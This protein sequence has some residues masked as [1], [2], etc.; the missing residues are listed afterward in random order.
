MNHPTD[1]IARHVTADVDIS[2]AKPGLC[3]V[4]GQETLCI[5]RDRAISEAF[6]DMRFCASPLSPVVSV[7]VAIAWKHGYRIPGKKRIFCPERQAC[8][9]V[10][11]NQF[12]Q[13]S[14]DEILFIVLHGAPSTPWAGW[15]T[16][17][18]RKHGSIR[19]PINHHP[20]GIWGFDEAKPDCRD[21][22]KVNRMYDFMMGY[23]AHGIGKKTML[24][25]TAPSHIIG[26]IG[27]KVWMDFLQWSEPLFYSQLYKFLVYLLPAKGDCNDSPGDDERTEAGQD[28]SIPD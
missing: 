20:H 12:R 10:D 17:K 1:L 7:N 18:Y 23:Y 15:A 16:E 4:T 3:F 22:Y 2:D 13:I 24:Y 21:A 14:R 25:R 9:Y 26:K 8:W 5:P 27:I 28:S 11:E 6:T 19:A